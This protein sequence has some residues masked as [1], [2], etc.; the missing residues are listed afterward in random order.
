LFYILFTPFQAALA[1][2]RIGLSTMKRIS[3]AILIFQW[4][5]AASAQQHYSKAVMEKIVQVES[6]LWERMVI[7]GKYSTLPER[8]SILTCRD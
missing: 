7:D 5:P 2:Y 3:L 6:R 1:G 4:L 8:M